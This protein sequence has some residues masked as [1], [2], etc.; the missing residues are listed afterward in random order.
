M[1]NNMAALG[2]ELHQ[3]RLG[4]SGTLLI[5]SITHS[6]FTNLSAVVNG[7]KQE[8]RL[9]SIKLSVDTSDRLIELQ[10]RAASCWPP[11]GLHK[12]KDRA[13]AVFHA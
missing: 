11:V 9:L 10:V 4:S 6:V 8:F 5:G 2:R 3:L 12:M 7:L 1:R 13:V